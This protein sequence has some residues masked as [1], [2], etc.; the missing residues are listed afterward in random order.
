VPIPIGER[1]IAKWQYGR[2]TQK[3]DAKEKKS[4]KK[5][6]ER[7]SAKFLTS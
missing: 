4:G 3:E 6:Y 2:R 5:Y 1:E 7:F